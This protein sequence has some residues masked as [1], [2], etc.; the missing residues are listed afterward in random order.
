MVAPTVAAMLPAALLCVG[1]L[2]VC[3]GLDSPIHGNRSSVNGGPCDHDE[4]RCAKN[5][6]K[7]THGPTLRNTWSKFDAEVSLLFRS[8][9]ESQTL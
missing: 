4:S 3:K 8:P 1:R 6:Q 5:C 2:A 7:T 9:L